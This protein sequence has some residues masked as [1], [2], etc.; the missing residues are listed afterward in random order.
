MGWSRSTG[1][2][3]AVQYSSLSSEIRRVFGETSG[4]FSVGFLGTLLFENEG[5]LLRKYS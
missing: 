3:G 2:L 1:E 4:V 5:L